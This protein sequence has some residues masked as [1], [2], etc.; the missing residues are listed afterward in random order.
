MGKKIYSEEFK[1]EALRSV[2][3]RGISIAQAAREL[4][5]K[6]QTLHRW[7]QVQEKE[8]RPAGGAGVAQ[9]SPSQELER[10]RRENVRL[11]AERDILKKALGYFAKEPK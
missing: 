11:R 2:R 4:G 6:Q 3:E 7:K 9:R 10:L 8:G 5:I 1:L